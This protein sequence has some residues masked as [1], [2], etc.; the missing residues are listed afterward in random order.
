MADL[1][2][3]HVSPGRES[4]VDQAIVQQSI[5][6]L[7]PPQ[8]QPS[9]QNV[10]VQQ[11]HDTRSP[12]QSI[13]EH[14]G[15]TTRTTM[16]VETVPNN[17]GRRDISGR[18]FRAL[19]PKA[20]GRQI[21]GSPRGYPNMTQDILPR[22]AYHRTTPLESYES[23][24]A[25]RINLARV[26]TSGNTEVNSPQS[27]ERASSVDWTLASAPPAASRWE[28]AR[29]Y[30]RRVHEPPQVDARTDTTILEVELNAEFWVG[31]LTQAMA[32]IK[33]VKDTE[34]SHAKKMFLPDSS[35]P[36]LIEATCREIF[37]SL[38]DRCNNGFRGPSNFNKALKLNKE[39]E[40]DSTA[41]CE[42]RLQNI[43]RALTWNKRCHIPCPF[44][45]T[46]S[47]YRSIFNP[48]AGRT[49]Y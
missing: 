6:Q 28:Q 13:S 2:N 16:H 10:Q 37:S 45:Q 42:E 1:H 35:D 24:E 34:G 44:P 30:R 43:I 5:A 32:N 33:N 27:N 3:D 49:R 38:I 19:L 11:R 8:S 12:Y 36:L 31:Q 4:D 40:S 25:D 22:E 23:F 15:P 14:I 47:Q 29:E 7:T 21:P 20:G 18:L 17:D 39:T 9:S 48:E 41:T 46:H 26:S